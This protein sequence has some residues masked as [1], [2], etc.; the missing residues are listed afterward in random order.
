M[1]KLMETIWRMFPQGKLSDPQ[2]STNFTTL[3]DKYSVPTITRAKRYLDIRPLR[4]DWRWWW[5]APRHSPQEAV[6]AATSV[7]I[8]RQDEARKTLQRRE[9]PS[10]LALQRIMEENNYRVRNIDAQRILKE[11]GYAPVTISRA[12]RELALASVKD[13]DEYHRYWVMVDLK[14]VEWLRATVQGKW[15]ALYPLYD[16]AARCGLHKDVIRQVLHGAYG[17]KSMRLRGVVGYI[18]INDPPPASVFSQLS[19]ARAQRQDNTLVPY[20]TF[21]PLE[22]NLLASSLR[23]DYSLATTPLPAETPPPTAYTADDLVPLTD[24]DSDATYTEE[25]PE[26]WP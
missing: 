3:C 22:E 4:R 13:Q 23:T 19:V 17:F 5:R 14:V 18:D 21:P 10:V 11:M 16:A 9:R 12:Y 24:D 7:N 1:I 6:E 8:N 15:V 2:P 26:D 25:E 20:T